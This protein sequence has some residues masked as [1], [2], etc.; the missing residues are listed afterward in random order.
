MNLPE[1]QRPLR[2]IVPPIVTPLLSDDELDVQGLEKLVERVIKGGVDALF[3]LGTTGEGPN[4]N[5]TVRH[6]MVE[7]VCDLVAGRIPIL[8]GITDM[9]LAE[10]VRLADSAFSAGASAVVAAPP[11]YLRMTQKELGAYYKELAD[12]CR[13]PLFLYNMP[14]CTKTEISPELAHELS[15][16]RNIIGIKDSSGDMEYLRTTTELLKSDP[17]FTVLLGPERQLSYAM[18]FGVHGGVNG[19]ANMF[20]EI[21]VDLHRAASAGDTDTVERLNQIINQIS[22]TIYDTYDAAARH[23]LTTKCA[24]F[25]LGLINGYVAWPFRRLGEQTEKKIADAVEQLLQQPEVKSRS[26]VYERTD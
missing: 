3:A 18:S 15:R 22:E 7:H 21:Y 11:Y 14:G 23:M 5:Y 1:M 25:A 12:Q 2:G 16:H 26:Q 10:S 9:V 4:L 17:S 20:P 24:V 13:L 19:G 8:I 6:Q